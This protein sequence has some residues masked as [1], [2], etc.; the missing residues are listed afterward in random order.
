MNKDRQEN[1]IQKMA[2]EIFHRNR[3]SG[4]CTH[5]DL[6]KNGYKKSDV[7]ENW[8]EATLR[9][10]KIKPSQIRMPNHPPKSVADI[11]I[12]LPSLMLTTLLLIGT[13][14]AICMTGIE[15]V[16]DIGDACAAYLAS[17]ALGHMPLLY[18]EMMA[19]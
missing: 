15:S 10:D 8:A 5:N 11:R 4:F 12:H 17:A 2:E 18:K 9:A 1:I 3:M 13:T 14:F 16:A 6:I 19:V 7:L